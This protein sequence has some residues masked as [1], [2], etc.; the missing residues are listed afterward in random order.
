MFRLKKKIS[1]IFILC[2]KSSEIFTNFF[3]ML[4]RTNETIKQ[5]YHVNQI[6]PYDTYDWHSIYKDVINYL[7]NHNFIIFDLTV[8]P[9][10]PHRIRKEWNTPFLSE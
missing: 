8:P 3:Y 5:F 7:T 2:R 4:K 6:C 9:N 10:H 1:G